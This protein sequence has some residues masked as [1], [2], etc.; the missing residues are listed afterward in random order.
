VT[1]YLPLF[2]YGTLL[3][4][5]VQE[6]VLGPSVIRIDPATAK[7]QWEEVPGDPGASVSDPVTEIRGELVWLLPERFEA[8]LQRVDQYEGA[9]NLF[10]RVR[11]RVQTEGEEVAAYA[12]EWVGTA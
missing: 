12:Y 11:I 5:R 4:R 7:G 10:K 9:S 1:E 8:C 6:L 2:V 3:D